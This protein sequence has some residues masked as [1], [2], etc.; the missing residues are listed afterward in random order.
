MRTI[1]AFAAAGA[2]AVIAGFAALLLPHGGALPN[3]PDEV[4]VFRPDRL[5]KLSDENLVDALIAQSFSEPIKRT[6]IKGAALSIDFV[7]RPETAEPDA[8]LEDLKKLV[9]LSFYRTGN[10]DRLLVRFVEARGDSVRTDGQ[11]DYGL[12]LAADVRRNDGWLSAG[13]GTLEAADL[14]GDIAW[15]QRLRLSHTADWTERFGPPGAGYGD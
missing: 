12:L 8:L 9:K 2:V 5:T 1:K 15:R 10:V 6:F 7:V 13:A 3:R 11:E 4:A 14:L